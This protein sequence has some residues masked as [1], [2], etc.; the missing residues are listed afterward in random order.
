M[1]VEP[2][3]QMDYILAD[4]LPGRGLEEWGLSG[5][6]INM[7]RY[8]EDAN[9]FWTLR[10]GETILLIGGWHRVW[11]G[12]CEVSLFPTTHFI[13]RPVGALLR[14][15]KVLNALL[16][17]HRRVQL[18]CRKEE[19]FMGFAQRLGFQTEGTLRKFGYDGSDHIIMSM[20][21]ETNA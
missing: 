19:I 20:V 4:L 7:L 6:V 16:K 12:V 9:T 5:G 10:D 3:K 18:N 8:M 14:L 17:G 11:N 13:K 15:K 2:F 21:G 1:K